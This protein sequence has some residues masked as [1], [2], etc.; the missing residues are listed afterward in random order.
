MKQGKEGQE[1]F[2]E[3]DLLHGDKVVTIR[4]NITS[5]SKASKWQ[6]DR[7]KVTEKDVKVRRVTKILQDCLTM[8]F[9]FV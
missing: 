1:S 6:I 5:D 4:R 7:R 3:I 8:H 2:T 9:F